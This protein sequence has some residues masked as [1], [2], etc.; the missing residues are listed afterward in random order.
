MTLSY[1]PRRTR[2]WLP[3]IIAVLIGVAYGV[4]AWMFRDWTAIHAYARLWT[5]EFRC[6]HYSVDPSQIGYD[7]QTSDHPNPRPDEWGGGGHWSRLAVS[8]PI[9]AA[10]NSLCDAATAPRAGGNLFVGSPPTALLYLHTLE[11]HTG[12]KRIVL[13]GVDTPTPGIDDD[14]P[15]LIDAELIDPDAPPGSQNVWPIMLWQWP[16]SRI[17]HELKIHMGEPVAGDPSAFRLR[18]TVDGHEGELEGRLTDNG[19]S[20]VLTDTTS[21]DAT[22]F[23]P[24]P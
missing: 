12:T 7:E 23:L 9:P 22:I 5:L 10:F 16:S 20:F 1:A 4:G 6:G 13:I 15:A 3:L 14:V 17:R 2:R 21:A 24:T 11:S 8:V 19:P 18:Y